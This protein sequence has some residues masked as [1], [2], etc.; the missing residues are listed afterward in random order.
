MIKKLRKMVSDLQFTKETLAQ[1]FSCEFCA[2]NGQTHSNNAS[3]VRGVFR[4]LSTMP[5]TIFVKRFILDVWQGPEYVFVCQI[6]SFSFNKTKAFYYIYPIRLSSLWSKRWGQLFLWQLAV[7]LN[8]YFMERLVKK[9][10]K[11]PRNHMW[12]HNGIFL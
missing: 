4:T 7:P 6:S 9:I 3:A 5:L 10:W 2:Q 1:L 8:Q 11:I 12:P